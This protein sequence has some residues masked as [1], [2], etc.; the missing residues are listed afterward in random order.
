MRA[1]YKK[2]VKRE[3]K[4]KVHIYSCTHNF[5]FMQLLE[6]NRQ[7]TYVC[8]TVP[9]SYIYYQKKK[10]YLLQGNNILS[11]IVSSFSLF[12]ITLYMSAEQQAKDACRVDP[13][14]Q[15]LLACMPSCSQIANV[16]SCLTDSS[17]QHEKQPDNTK[18]HRLPRSP[19][20]RSRSRHEEQTR[21][22]KLLLIIGTWNYDNFR[23]SSCSG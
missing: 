8:N 2:F 20:S 11:I 16:P 3:T 18:H 13:A 10:L 5:L 6:Y 4:T 1:M 12:I 23:D 22:D 17:C 19:I 7:H 9:N 21:P 14:L 15:K